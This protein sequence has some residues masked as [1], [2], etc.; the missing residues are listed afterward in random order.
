[1]KKKRM[2]T[3][4]IVFWVL[5]VSI[6]FCCSVLIYELQP[7]GMMKNKYIALAKIIPSQQDRWLS[8][9][10]FHEIDNLF[11]TIP[12]EVQE[13]PE[14]GNVWK[15]V[16][17]GVSDQNRQEVSDRLKAVFNVLSGF[18]FYGEK[19]SQNGSDVYLLFRDLTP[20]FI[21]EIPTRPRYRVAIVIDDVG[22][23]RNY[24]ELFLALPQKITYAIFPHL[25]L[26]KTIG[27]RFNEQGKEILIHLP[28]E[29]LDSKQNRNEILLLRSGDDETRIRD[30]IKKAVNSLPSA[31]G[32]NNHKGSKATQDSKL[33]N[34][35]MTILKEYKLN[36]LDS[37][38]SNESQA[39]ETAQGIGLSSYRRDI[40][41][42]GNTSIEYIVQK[43]QETVSQ[44]RKKGYAIAIGHAKPATYKALV[45]FFHSMNDPEV[46]FVFLS[47]LPVL[48]ENKNQIQPKP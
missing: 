13:N 26:S 7:E 48:E 28:M 11:P 41:L 18:G 30:M 27:Q 20:W 14:T 36:F 3:S 24:A 21:L 47:D 8:L 2:T 46:E 23:N 33:M 1:M 45:S 38:T 19:R 34:R 6:L 15:V 40:F 25:P 31:R 42:D 32:L 10:I 35:L 17:K 16:V 44:A 39:Y 9:F 43:L 4:R 37:V 5:I 22:Y 29:A 12:I